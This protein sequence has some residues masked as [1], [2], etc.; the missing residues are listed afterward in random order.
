M[1]NDEHL[2]ILDQGVDT[3]NQWRK[4]NPEALP[5]LTRADLVK[6]DLARADLHDADLRRS[7]LREAILIWANLNGA[8]LVGAN[9]IGAHLS[10]ANLIGADLRKAVLI[11]AN[12]RDAC[13][14]GAN[15]TGADLRGTDFAGAN[16]LAA[17]LNVGDLLGAYLDEVSY[18]SLA[19][20]STGDI[21]PS[22]ALVLDRSLLETRHELE[23]SIQELQTAIQNIG[24]KV[25]GRLPVEDLESLRQAFSRLSETTQELTAPV[26]IPSREEM[27][28][29]LVPLNSLDRLEEYRFETDFWLAMSGI[30][31]GAA[32]GILVNLATGG[33]LTPAAWVLIVVLPLIA[34]GTVSAAL[35]YVR[36]GRWIVNRLKGEREG[37]E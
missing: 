21:G 22:G 3:W 36:R 13:L 7:N 17:K 27:A 34:V 12:L 1:A 6:L 10:R 35:R 25:E 16:L 9:L 33:D 24:K 8:Y 28:V 14:V 5:D 26:T 18:Q 23:A 29:R 4:E 32:L 19:A 20:T 2:G 37:R 11:E 15:L 31:V 30:L